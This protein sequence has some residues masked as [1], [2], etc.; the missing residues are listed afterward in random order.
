MQKEEIIQASLNIL[1]RDGLEGVTLRRLASELN[2]KAASIY[3]HI[4]N[5]EAL[6]DEMANTILEEHFAEF[7]FANDRRDWAEWL[8]ILA[9]ELRAAML[10]HRDGARIVA[11]AHP[12]IALM[13]LT[14][15]DISVRI[16]RN[17]GFS[18]SKAMTITVTVTNFT[19]GSVIEEQASPLPDQTA[20]EL[21]PEAL[22]L[23]D[24]FP[25]LAQAMG[26]WIDEDNDMRFDTSVRII[27]DGVRVAL[28]ASQRP[29]D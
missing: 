7:D 24:R 12:Q 29:I 27:I 14:L 25:V 15:W 9:H 21:S 13:L 28:D 3:W 19:F 23:L 20:P 26:A 17:N 2:V 6:F 18:Y 4:A 10:A 16:L 22:Q 5:K 1:D 11:G 8:S